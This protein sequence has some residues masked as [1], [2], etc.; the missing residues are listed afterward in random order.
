[1]RFPLF[2]AIALAG[3]A[4]AGCV[5]EQAEPVNEGE[6]TE[7]LWTPGPGSHP[8]FGYPISTEL[9]LWNESVSNLPD[10]WKQPPAR[11]LP[12]TLNSLVHRGQV[13]GTP[14]GAG[15][16]VWGPYAYVGSYDSYE[17]AVI[18]I[19]DPEVPSV[20]GITDEAPAG[21]TDI[22]AY[23]DGRLI[24]VT[25]TRGANMMVIDVTDPTAPYLLST[26]E[27][28]N[29]NHNHAI[30]PGTPIVYNNDSGGAGTNTDIWDLSD[31]ENPV[32]V[33]DWANGYGCHA[34][35][36][37]IDAERD[38]YRGY[39]AGIETTQIWDIT[40][41]IDPQVITTIPWP[42]GGVD[43]GGLIPAVAPATFSHLAMVNHDATVLIV[44][45][46]TGGGAAPGCDAYA[47]VPGVG[48]V[49][50]PLGNLFFYDITDETNPVLHGSYSPAAWEQKGSCTAH[51]GGIIEDTNHLVM[52]F[53]TAGIALVDFNDLDNPRAVDLWQRTEGDGP[54]TLCGVWDAQYY[55]GYVFSGDVDRGMDV[56]VLG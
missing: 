51:F 1:M 5:D 56:L 23:P 46:E 33:N 45:D 19:S 25:S 32:M 4:L 7:N 29:G 47:E 34:S 14:S 6:G 13:T 8:A 40:D 18:D 28:I 9:P 16:A 43:S 24:A 2:A 20:L 10:H 42:T 35:S 26:I 17:F 31:P 22:I 53:Y 30:V 15:I 55:N 52:A 39:C 54:C 44:G 48:T 3:L 37:F 41:P 50:G 12:E 38:F 21:D 11:E 36:F 49:T 27:T